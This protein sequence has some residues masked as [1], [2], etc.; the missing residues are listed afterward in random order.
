M[1]LQVGPKQQMRRRGV[2][3]Q[4]A[5]S[6]RGTTRGKDLEKIAFLEGPR[7]SQSRSCLSRDEYVG[8]FES[9]PIFGFGRGVCRKHLSQTLRPFPKFAATGH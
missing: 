7:G 5:E 1:E 4:Q 2:P 6:D 3:F 8:T 9:F